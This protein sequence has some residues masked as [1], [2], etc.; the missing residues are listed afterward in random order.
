MQAVFVE[1]AKNRE[2]ADGAKISNNK[3][4]LI[5]HLKYTLFNL[6]LLNPYT[7]DMLSRDWLVKKLLLAT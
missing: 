6:T 5:L 3:V 7:K 1:P 2:H 4:R